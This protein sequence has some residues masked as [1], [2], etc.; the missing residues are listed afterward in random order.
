MP[1]ISKIQTK[2]QKIQLQIP[3][4]ISYPWN[5]LALP[6][7]LAACSVCSGTG[8]VEFGHGS[9]KSLVPCRCV[10]RAVFRAALTGYYDYE[11]R[12]RYISKVTLDVLPG[13]DKMGTWGRKGEEYCA[14]FFLVSRRSLEPAQWE[15]FKM[16][17][18]LKMDW[19]FCTKRL[20][21]DRGSFFHE[22]YRIEASLGKIYA[23]LLPYPLFPIIDYMHG[24]SIDSINYKS[25]HGWKG[26]IS[27][28]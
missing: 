19:K 20:G 13:K 3:K 26:P 27:I 12:E 22:V 24:A 28:K 15:L 10:L 4:P 1:Q 8:S 5:N 9:N 16:H 11:E 25:D 7:S 18:L 17:F 6:N 23:E 14:D 2:I 21:M